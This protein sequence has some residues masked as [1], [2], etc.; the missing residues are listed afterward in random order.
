[1]EAAG[2]WICSPIGRP[3]LNYIESISHETVRKVLKNELKPHLRKCWCIPPEQNAA[4]V[5]AMEDVLD[6]YQ[7]LYDADCPVICMVKSRTN[8]WMSLGRL[9]SLVGKIANTFDTKRAASLSLQNPWQVGGMLR[10]ESNELVST[11]QSKFANC[12]TSIIQMCQR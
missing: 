3:E 4:F 7:L 11:G 9:P 1:M 10:Y 2:L 5:A 8:C 12:W 6:V